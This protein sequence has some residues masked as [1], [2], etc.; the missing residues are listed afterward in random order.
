[1]SKL[2]ICEEGKVCAKCKQYLLK[3]DFFKD[4][5]KKFAMSSRCKECT[6]K[7][8]TQT[9]VYKERHRLASAKYRTERPSYTRWHVTNSTLKA[10]YGIGLKEYE[11]MF[12][13]QNGLCAICLKP[14]DGAKRLAVDHCHETLKVRG[15]LCFDCNTSI[16]KFNHDIELLDRAINYLKN[17]E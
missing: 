3:D 7:H 14:Q 17:Y 15:L 11:E 6:R 16:G 4:S 5:S 9:P 10:K 12:Q 8:T 2:K 1:M 13:K